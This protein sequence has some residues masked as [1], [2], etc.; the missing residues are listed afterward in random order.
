MKMLDQ[1]E[2]LLLSLAGV[3]IAWK[4][5]NRIGLKIQDQKSLSHI[6]H[7]AVSTNVRF[8]VEIDWGCSFGHKD[9]PN[10]LRYDLRFQEHDLEVFH[11]FLEQDIKEI[12][13]RAG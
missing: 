9:D 8:V 2:K 11:A 6:A 7:V 5:N 13:E 1:I 4:Q 10:C 12:N 3:Q